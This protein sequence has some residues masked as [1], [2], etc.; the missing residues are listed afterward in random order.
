MLLMGVRGCVGLFTL[1]FFR[2][3]LKVDK[4]V[5]F[6]PFPL[7]CGVEKWYLDW[8]ITSRPRFES[9]PRYMIYI[10]ENKLIIEE[11][12]EVENFDIWTGESEGKRDNI[13]GVIEGPN[14][15]GFCFR[16]DMSYK[17][18]G[19][20]W[21]DFFY[22]FHGENDEFERLC[23]ELGISLVT[24]PTVRCW[25]CKVVIDNSLSDYCAECMETM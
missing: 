25:G 9:W 14:E 2:N 4:G 15:M 8:L 12:L 23:D 18:K 7:D 24:M 20:Q 3:F 19:D 16:I 22:K 21:T 10:K 11:P 17:G 13:V 5:R 1:L 6:P